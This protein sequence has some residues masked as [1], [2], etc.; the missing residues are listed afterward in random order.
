MRSI[1]ALLSLASLLYADSITVP[2]SGVAGECS[3]APV[4]TVSYNATIPTPGITG[5]Y[6]LPK[7]EYNK[8]V[9]ASQAPSQTPVQF[10]YYVD[11]SCTG[12]GITTCSQ[13]TAAS[14]LSSNDTTCV[15][16]V[17]A[18]TNGTV[19]GVLNVQFGSSASSG[20]AVSGG[21]VMLAAVAV[22]SS[23]LS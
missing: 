8:L 2:G 14:V 12:G 13:T 22:V 6:L 21:V 5:V 19:T 11:Y 15:A 18:G 3:S 16:L 4:N 10:N 23:L 9:A 20:A 1:L 17:N 7:T